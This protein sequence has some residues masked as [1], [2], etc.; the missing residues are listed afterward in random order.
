VAVVGVGGFFDA[1]SDLLGVPASIN[2]VNCFELAAHS[3]AAL[4]PA[5]FVNLGTHLLNV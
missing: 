2:T 5:C 1:R 4:E 3:P